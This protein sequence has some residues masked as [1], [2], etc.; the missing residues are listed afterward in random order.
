MEIRSKAGFPAGSLSNFA[1]HPFV[2]DGVRCAS[3]EG[4]LQSL[5]FASPDMQVEVCTLVGAKA[6]KRGAKKNWQQAQTLYWRGEPID[7]H[8]DA[9]QAL[10][11]RA[12]DALAR[13][14][15]FRRALA[16]TG[17]ATLTHTMGRRKASETVLTRQEFT[18]RLHRLRDTL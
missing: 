15:G 13:N 17:S 4:F 12:F 11:D 6:K 9:Y 8:G 7:R 10:L 1:P 16:A 2:L 5:K 14:A 3:M 18:S